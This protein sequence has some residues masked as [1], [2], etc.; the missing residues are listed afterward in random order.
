M[1]LY[2]GALYLDEAVSSILAQTF[3]DFELIVV[4]DGSTDDGWEKLATYSDP[5][6]VKVKRQH[7]GLVPTLN[8]GL[9]LARGG[10]VARMDADDVALPERLAEQVL[11]MESNPEIGL[12]SASLLFVDEAGRPV[13]ARDVPTD[14]WEIRWELLFENP[15]MHSAVILRRELL[16]GEGVAYDESYHRAEDY[17]LW[18][19]L[20]RRT[21]GGNISKR[22]VRYRLHSASATAR[23]HEAQ[24][25]S[26]YR[27]ALRTI[28]EELPDIDITPE[29]V[30]DL[31]LMLASETAGSA[32]LRGRRAQLARL[33]FSIYEAFRRRHPEMRGMPLRGAAKLARG[34]SYGRDEQ[35]WASVMLRLVRQCPGLPLFA[36]KQRISQVTTPTPVR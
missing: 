30:R 10:Y 17:E 18:A 12:S 6:I 14:D 22:L 19:R 7:A 35:G 26:H 16:D 29:Q 15:F 3:E 24:M 21:R 25:E 5:R 27:V 31:E 2:N 36:L 20:L 32:Q 8:H 33:Y 9:A 13:N 11:Y 4:D 34:L 1:P 28:G 23:E